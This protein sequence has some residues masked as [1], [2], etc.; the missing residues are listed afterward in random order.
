[1]SSF[2]L[3]VDIFKAK[4]PSSL[5]LQL[6]EFYG[7]VY[8]LIVGL[9]LLVLLYALT[10]FLLFRRRVK[11]KYVLFEVKPLQETLQSSFST[12]QL[13]N[14]IHSLVKQ[15]SFLE[16]LFDSHK[17]RYP[18]FDVLRISDIVR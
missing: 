5:F 10:K 13:F 16:K 12:Q 15:R 6:E 4:L 14:V 17:S 7:L 11:H 18:P 8:S 3:L 1:M 9:L 2:S